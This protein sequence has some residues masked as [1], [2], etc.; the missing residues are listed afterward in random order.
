MLRFLKY[1]LPHEDIDGNKNKYI[2]IL[3][4]FLNYLYKYPLRLISKNISYYN[5]NKILCYAINNSEF[6]QIKSTKEFERRED[7]WN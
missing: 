4:N 6:G 5:A 3:N 2:V 7:L 1:F